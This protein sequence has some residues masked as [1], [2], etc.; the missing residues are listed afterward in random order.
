LGILKTQIS[1]KIF[2]T[3]YL[4]ITFKNHS[5]VAANCRRLTVISIGF[6]FY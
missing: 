1:Q 3:Y 4:S 5:Y 6:L 2:P